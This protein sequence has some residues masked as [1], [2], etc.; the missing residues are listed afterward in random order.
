V[1]SQIKLAFNTKIASISVDKAASKVA[2]H[3]AKKLNADGD[4]T[5]PL[6]DPAHCIDL[7]SKELE[8]SSVVCTVLAEAKEVLDFCRTN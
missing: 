7:L 2:N 5:L 6:H 3:V 8:K 4:A 1:C